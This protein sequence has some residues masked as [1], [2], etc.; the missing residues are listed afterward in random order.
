MAS[1]FISM[2]RNIVANA[3]WFVDFALSCNV[4][5]AADDRCTAREANR[6]T[7]VRSLSYHKMTS[8]VRLSRNIDR[9]RFCL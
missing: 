2:M 8:A 3:A 7:N 4:D 1:C 9:W 6:T 5:R